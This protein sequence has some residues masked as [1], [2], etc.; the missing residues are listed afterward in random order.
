MNKLYTSLLCIG[1]AIN[2]T[3]TLQASAGLRRLTLIATA[4]KGKAQ[5]LPKETPF[6]PV[7]TEGMYNYLATI[8]DSKTPGVTKCKTTPSM[9]KAKLPYKHVY[10]TFDNPGKTMDYQSITDRSGNRFTTMLHP[11][12]TIRGQLWTKD[13]ITTRQY[14]DET[15]KMTTHEQSQRFVYPD[16]T[17]YTIDHDLLENKKSTHTYLP[18][19]TQFHEYFDSNGKITR[20]RFGDTQGNYTRIKY[21]LDGNIIDH[22]ISIKSNDDNIDST[23]YNLTNKTIRQWTKDFCFTEFDATGHITY[24]S[25]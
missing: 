24:K 4:I 7:V 23:N 9:P 5:F 15:G 10:S 21:D 14:F 17:S 25:K 19:K 13:G 20:T 6:L 8:A 3:D 16:K 2:V 18:N 11:D 12:N 1:I 22:T